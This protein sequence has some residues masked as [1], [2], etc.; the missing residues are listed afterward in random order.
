MYESS[1][2]NCTSTFSSKCSRPSE[3]IFFRKVVA[4][5]ETNT[6]LILKKI[7]FAHPTFK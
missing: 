1:K 7:N 3:N 2:F 6:K 4:L 5:E